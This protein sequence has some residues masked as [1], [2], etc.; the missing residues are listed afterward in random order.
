MLLTIAT[1]LIF[2]ELKEKV[3][4]DMF[5]ELA[6]R[7]WGEWELRLMIVVSSILQLFLL[8][9]GSI[10]RKYLG[11]KLPY[12]AI[13]VWLVYLSADWM[14]TL[15]L[16]TLLRGDARLK[17][18]LI[19]LWTSFLLWHLGSPHTIT[20]YSLEDNELWLRHFF[21]LV[22]QVG[23]AIY[24][25]ARFRS[26]SNT[27]LNAVA[28]PILLAGVIKYGER[29][30][31]LRCASDK[32]LL[33]SFFSISDNKIIKGGKKI[34]RT[35]LSKTKINKL[36]ES[37][38][39]VPE[40]EFLRQAYISYI[41]FKPLFID[42]PFRLSREFHDNMVFM[43]SKSAEDAFKFVDV[44]LSFVY[45]MFFTKNP[46]QY[47]HLKVSVCLR[48]FCFLSA[49]CSLIAF[50]AVLDKNKHSPIDI[51]ITYLLLV[52]AISLDFYSFLMHALSTWAMIKLPLPRTKV[53]KT[54]SRVVASRLQSIKVRSG[55]K[56]MAQHD[57][58]KYCVKAKTSWFTGAIKLFDTGNLLQK[59][60]H[61][62]WKPVDPDLKNF[63]YT[64]L[65]KKREKFERNGFKLDELEKL[66]NEKGDRVFKGKYREMVGTDADLEEYKEEFSSIFPRMDSVYF[67]RSIFLWHIATELAYYDDHDNHRVDTAHSL[68]NISKSISDYMIYLTLVRPSMLCK[69]FSDVINGKIY[70]EAQIFLTEKMKTRFIGAR[71]QFTKDLLHFV[72][73]Q[74]Q[75]FYQ[76]PHNRVGA[77]LEGA[78]FA[79]KLQR[80]PRELRWDHD[81]KWEMISEVWMEMMTH[82]ASYC[83]WREHAQQLRHGGELLTHV[84]LVMAHLGLSTKV[85]RD[86]EDD[87]PH[88]FPPFDA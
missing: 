17:N 38:G 27:A 23:E 35:G 76:P 29:V 53:H 61:T 21:G 25:Y 84:A 40:V 69:G 20:A 47:R 4:K 7:Y 11:K 56:S 63:I 82:A 71:K 26:K 87:D 31:A 15:V 48:G 81:E 10:R 51:A 80:F 60:G 1:T 36:F 68:S 37:E 78:S 41:V 39:I 13:S 3:F 24:I 2:V 33:N 5:K 83:S 57:L 67:I 9:S 16:T 34:I 22:F 74:Q 65:I 59:Y 19:V 52:G 30:W 32:Q 18:E 49:I 64:H 28:A 86:E 85:G 44:E 42:L 62:K 12:V 50:T 55:I 58:I 75:S 14:A 70:K 54:Y 72:A 45:D 6:K 77:L 66:L 88:A 8:I 79:V 73:F 46:I 43:K